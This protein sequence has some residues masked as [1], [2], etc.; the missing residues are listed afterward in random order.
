[1]NRTSLWVV[2]SWC[3]F[4]AACAPP[5]AEEVSAAAEEPFEAAPSQTRAAV[6]V[7]T[8]PDLQVV[9][10]TA[11]FTAVARHATRP[12]NV[13]VCN[14]G[15]VASTPVTVSVLVSSNTTINTADPVVGTATFPTLEPAA[16]HTGV[17]SA[18]F[19]PSV[20]TYYLA[21]WADRADAINEEVE[22]NNSLAGG[23]LYI[24]NRADVTVSVLAAP[25]SSP[26]NTTFATQLRACNLGSSTAASITL[27][28]RR[29]TDTTI[30][31]SDPSMGSTYIG[32]LA[33]GA[34]QD[35][36]VNGTSAAFSERFLGARVSTTSTEVSTANN[37][38]LAGPFAVGNSA[39]L[40]IESTSHQVSGTVLSSTVLVCNRGYTATA[41]SELS[42]HVSVD[43]VYDANDT[44]V[45]NTTV[46]FLGVGACASV[47][48][49]G[50]LPG[51][52]G[53]RTPL[54]RVDATNA[55]AELF[56]TNNVAAANALVLGPDLRISSFEVTFDTSLL[57]QGIVCNEGTADAAATVIDV[58]RSVAPLLDAGDA[59]VMQVAIPATNPGTCLNFA[60]TFT[61]T[62]GSG[63]VFFIAH[64]D[65]TDAVAETN[66]LNNTRVS[67]PTTLSVDLNAESTAWV[68]NNAFGWNVRICN[69]G[70]LPAP[71]QTVE[72][73][74]S[75]DPTFDAQDAL[76]YTHLASTEI[77]AR[78]CIDLYGSTPN[79]GRGLG[80]VVAAVDVGDLVAESNEQ[81]NTAASQQLSI[82]INPFFGPGTTTVS[83]TG[84]NEFTVSGTLCTINR[85]SGPVTLEAVLSTDSVR[86]LGDV[87]LAPLSSNVVDLSSCVAFSVPFTGSNFSAGTFNVLV[88]AIPSDGSPRALEVTGPV[89]IGDDVVVSNVTVA[90]S[91][92][93]IDNV[94]TFSAQACNV[95]THEASAMPSG[96]LSFIEYPENPLYFLQPLSPTPVTIAP[97][98]CT[99]VTVPMHPGSSVPDATLFA[100]FELLSPNDTN[101]GNNL[102]MAPTPLLF[103][104]DFSVSDV[105]TSVVWDGL[106]NVFTYTALA[107]NH[108]TRPD[109]A[110]L[111]ATLSTDTVSNLGDFGFSSVN[112]WFSGH[113]DPGACVPV[114]AEF[115]SSSQVPDGTFFAFLELYTWNEANT[116]NNSAM[117]PTPLVLG[118]DIVTSNATATQWWN[119]S[120]SV[121]S[122]SATAC[123]QGTRPSAATAHGR[124][125]TDETPDPN[126]LPLSH[127]GSIWGFPVGPG[128]C[129]TITAD[130]YSP[131]PVPSGTYFLFVDAT[132]FDPEPTPA[133]N[134][135]L[136]PT[137]FS[138]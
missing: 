74:W 128:D 92:T 136:V 138:L 85:F 39:D 19:S 38:A 68:A 84:P 87:P 123:N 65:A 122:V 56:E 46:P 131:T 77:A 36:T 70:N 104:H 83:Q 11:G 129:T 102:A 89:A 54:A 108:G 109:H 12:V 22:S 26:P 34:C 55:V 90:V 75:S 82:G 114:T 66:E 17:V 5:D 45:S 110:S 4:L 18:V 116:A 62:G 105:T 121:F 32:S 120:D 95:G 16:C 86:D 137:A 96:R 117:A 3:G 113:I 80:H 59:V 127:L 41:P 2:V 57:A 28:V 76:L 91:W 132:T 24:G 40:V 103:G 50:V 53:L 112:T 23:T 25:I 107:C 60:Q 6:V 69:A 14:H 37:A 93:G 125:S 71:A 124:L 8:G 21:A 106:R 99:V 63:E 101:P 44:L 52:V 79:D 61:V 35:V 78:A 1:M 9:S 33:A 115:T 135:A 31:T 97:G 111:S 29:S 73:R 27:S 15:S 98:Q 42:V 88:E 49:F 126:D 13:T 81:N 48:T 20:G 134:T 7:P 47:M 10:V 130:L 100:F 118:V 64:V 58:F 119:D 43:S 94:L 133:N 72:V 51:V 67:A 30:T